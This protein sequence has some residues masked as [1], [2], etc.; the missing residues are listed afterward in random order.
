M[1]VF[2]LLVVQTES[3]EDPRLA[4]I[5]ILFPMMD[6]A[7]AK[8]IMGTHALT[9]LAILLLAFQLVAIIKEL[10]TKN[11]TTIIT[12]MGMDVIILPVTSNLIA[13]AISMLFPMTA[14]SA[15][16]IRGKDWRLAMTDSLW[17][18]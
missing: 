12:S 16:T 3:L 18:E 7:L 6:A 8:L 1:F 5:I 2:L 13:L 4:M 9:L 10:M 11:V 15:E 17:M 14:M